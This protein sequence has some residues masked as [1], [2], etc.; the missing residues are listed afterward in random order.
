MQSG[1]SPSIPSLSR[2]GSC[3]FGS[4]RKD[5][6]YDRLFPDWTQHRKGSKDGQVEIHFEADFFNTHRLK[7]N[8]PPHRSAKLTFHSFRGFF[9]QACHDAGIDA[10]TILKWVGHD[11]ETRGTLTRYIGAIWPGISPPMR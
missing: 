8:V 2:S 5:W 1:A 4:G 6:G 3:N 10:Y 7:W 9:I 11:E